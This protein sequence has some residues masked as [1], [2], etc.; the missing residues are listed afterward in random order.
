MRTLLCL[1]ML[2]SIDVSLHAQQLLK[3]DVRAPEA[4]GMTI[5][6]KDSAN[7]FILAF[8][9]SKNFITLQNVAAFFERED[10][11]QDTVFIQLALNLLQ[12]IDSAK[13]DSS[14]S[15]Y[16]LSLFNEKDSTVINEKSFIESCPEL[17]KVASIIM[18]KTPDAE[19][20]ISFVDKKGNPLTGFSVRQLNEALFYDKLNESL[21][22]LCGAGVPSKND[23]SKVTVLVNRFKK[24]NL[25]QHMLEAGLEVNDDDAYAGKL[26][27]RKNINVTMIWTRKIKK[28]QERK[29]MQET[30]RQ[31]ENKNKVFI[32]ED[33]MNSFNELRID[34][35]RHNRKQ[36]YAIA[37]QEI[38]SSEKQFIWT[39]SVGTLK[40]S[41]NSKDSSQAVGF[42]VY[43]LQIQF[44]DGFIENI[45][46]RGKIPG[47]DLLLKFE[48]SYPIPFSTRRDFRKLYEVNL[49]ERT[50]FERASKNNL[51]VERLKLRLGDLLDFDQ[52]LD[53]DSKDYSPVNQVL[54]EKIE[55]EET[56]VNL[57]KERT[58]K[59]LELKVFTDLK[60]IDNDNPNGLVQLELSKKMNFWNNRHKGIWNLYNIGYL[61]YLTPGFSMSKI[62]NNNKR[63]PVQYVGSQQPDSSRPNNFASTLQLLQYQAFRIGADLSLMTIDVPGLKSTLTIKTGLYFGRTLTVDTLRTKIDSTTFEPLNDNNIRESGVNSFQIIPEICLQIYPDKRYGVIL[64]YKAN[65]Y[66]VLSGEL[67]QVRDSVDYTG[68]IK[69]LN[70]D[71]S[72]ITGY[73]K[74]WWLG[75]AEIYAFYR[76]SPYNQLFFRYRFNYDM[77]EPKTNFHQIQ[78][79]FAT[80][81]THTSK[82]KK[83]QDRKI[84][85]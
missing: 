41:K 67:T 82:G 23:T 15:G 65:R 13:K 53:I 49:L 9:T 6:W 51:Q 22:G 61:N 39:E 76:P 29:L 63:L 58:S 12:L 3:V 47:N 73:P 30:K 45:K 56:V 18:N 46:V 40:I 16:N 75:S 11:K 17:T 1:I 80:Y 28:E 55:K 70:G 84:N 59:I 42:T 64:S 19:F 74:R 43:Y 31:A 83:E 24:M 27:I 33:R 2:V 71:R 48:N 62:E 69:S 25:Y 4:E 52:T 37:R 10:V 14:L 20:E 5:S 26:T 77:S 54:D 8:N 38:L 85:D 32:N 50:I 68:Y 35:S 79:G 72:K 66:R 44:Q 34:F 7:Q 81:L 60:G 36:G 21:Y 57:K 78:L